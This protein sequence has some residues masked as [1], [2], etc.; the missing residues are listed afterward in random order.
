M[1]LGKVSVRTFWWG[2]TNKVGLK[3]KKQSA[4]LHEQPIDLFYEYRLEFDILAGGDAPIDRDASPCVP[5]RLMVRPGD[6]TSFI[7]GVPPAYT[8][9]RP[10]A[11]LRGAKIV[12][13]F[14]ISK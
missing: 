1:V 7:A 2:V 6:R 10:H 13:F 8:G 4:A 12:L 11:G 3:I 5:G 14:E 9:G